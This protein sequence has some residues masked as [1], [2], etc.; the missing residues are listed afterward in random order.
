[1]ASAGIPGM[2]GL[3]QFLVFRGSFP[4]FNANSTMH[5]RDRLNSGLLPAAG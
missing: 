4:V 2:V 5:D 1:M 3:F